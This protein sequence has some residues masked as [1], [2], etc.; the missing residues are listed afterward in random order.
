MTDLNL[1][2]AFLCAEN[3]HILRDGF[4]TSRQVGSGRIV[5]AFHELCCPALCRKGFGE[6]FNDI[7]NDAFSNVKVKIDFKPEW[8]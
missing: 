7:D 6:W 5:G 2:W 8:V 3:I 1:S 4:N